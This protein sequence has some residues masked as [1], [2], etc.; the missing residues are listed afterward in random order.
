MNMR[1]SNAHLLLCRHMTGNLRQ[2]GIQASF[3]AILSIRLAEKSSTVHSS[4]GRQA[5]DAQ[6]GEAKSGIG[7]DTLDIRLDGNGQ[8][9]RAGD[10]LDDNVALLD[11]AAQQLVLC[12]LEQRLDDGRVPAGVDDADAQG[13]AVVLLRGRAFEGGSHCVVWWGYVL[14]ERDA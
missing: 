12:S 9:P 14:S 2:K 5:A 6:P 7:G 3:P 13:A 4:D 1:V 11:A 8:L 10:R